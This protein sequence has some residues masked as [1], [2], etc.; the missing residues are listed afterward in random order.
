MK[1]VH[2]TEVRLPDG[3]ALFLLPNTDIVLR[4]MPSGEALAEYQHIGQALV[5]Y[6]RL[7]TKAATETDGG[8]PGM[9]ALVAAFVIT[10]R[11]LGEELARPLKELLD[12]L[13]ASQHA[14]AHATA[15][16]GPCQQARWPP[17]PA[18]N[19]ESRLDGRTG[20]LQATNAAQPRTGRPP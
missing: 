13:G 11:L 6:Q 15:L 20:G 1:L 19:A 7:L 8:H 10:E 12:A 9:G 5:E 17:T 4:E 18:I 2:P 3:R 14:L 16:V